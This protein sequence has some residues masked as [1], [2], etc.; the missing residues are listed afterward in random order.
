MSRLMLITKEFSFDAA[1]QLPNYGGRCER[2]H[3]HTWTI[4]VTVEAPIDESTGIAF[5]FGELKE[6]VNRR[7]VEILDH[8]YLNDFL[9]HP[10]AENLCLWI[11]SEL[12]DLPLYEI[13]VWETPRSCATYRVRNE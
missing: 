8:T 10:S 3:G 13:R 4:H 5:D 12:E 1:H 2:L 9:E 6:I 11:A 7:V